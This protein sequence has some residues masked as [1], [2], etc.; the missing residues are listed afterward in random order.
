MQNV[1]QKLKNIVFGSISQSIFAGPD[2]RFPPSDGADHRCSCTNENV[3]QRIFTCKNWFRFSRQQAIFHESQK[4]LFLSDRELVVTCVHRFCQAFLLPST[5]THRIL[6]PYRVPRSSAFRIHQRYL[7]LRCIKTN[8]YN[9]IC[10]V[11]FWNTKEVRIHSRDSAKIEVQIFM[12]LGF[13]SRTNRGPRLH[14]QK[15]AE[16]EPLLFATNSRA[17]VFVWKNEEP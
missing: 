5:T 14:F 12:P 16:S 11:Q 7:V 1:Y 3:V 17:R 15:S 2:L 6:E 8:F 4:R 13:F 10:V 9:L